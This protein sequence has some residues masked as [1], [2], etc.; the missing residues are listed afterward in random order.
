MIV[1]RA[2]VGFRETLDLANLGKL[3]Y[4]TTLNSSFVARA[5]PTFPYFSIAP[6]ILFRL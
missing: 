6:N 2:H 1:A 4:A 5:E 3:D